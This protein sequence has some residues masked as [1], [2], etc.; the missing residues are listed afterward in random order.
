MTPPGAAGLLA[1]RVGL[2]IGFSGARSLAF[3][4]ARALV[5]HGARVGVTCRPGREPEVAGAVEA[6]GAELCLPLDPADDPSIQAAVARA[7]ARWERLDFVVHTLM[8]VPPG[9]LER[10]LV[11]L[12]R[13]E[14]LRVLDTGT[15]SLIR[16]CRHALP[17]LA[18]SSAPRVV[19]FSSG[20]SRR[21]SP[22]YHVAGI[23]KAALE[24]A[25]RYLAH[26]LGP[27]G[28][29][30]N[31]VSPSLVATTGA[32]RAVGS[33]AVTKTLAHLGRKSPTGRATEPADAAQWVAWL[34][35]PLAAQVTGEV[36]TIDGGYA[37]SYF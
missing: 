35:S 12:G 4:C 10:P 2:V 26:E 36:F 18:K 30:C 6:A 25:V 20:P 3:A 21:P 24:S 1:G 11:E 28:V 22:S 29:L 23:C 17:A 5:D 31:A 14:F 15:Y 16:I 8:E 34:C 7:V 32:E 37:A 9:A 13:D 33:D 27:Q 19:S